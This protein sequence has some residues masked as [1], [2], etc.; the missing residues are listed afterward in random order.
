M[1]AM[2]AVKNTVPPIP[3]YL[4]CSDFGLSWRRSVSAPEH[5]QKNSFIIMRRV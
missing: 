5:I 1:K 3:A 4:I 2:T